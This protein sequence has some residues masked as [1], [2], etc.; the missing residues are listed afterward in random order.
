[1]RKRPIRPVGQPTRGKT[2]LNRL[3][4]IDIY[5]ALAMPGVLTYGSPLVVDVGFGA[6][7]WTT[8]EMRQRWLHLNASLRVLGIEIAPERVEAALPYAA[9]PAI[10]FKL[11]G[12]NVLDATGG[13]RV[14][15]IRA[16]NVLRQY[17]ESEVGAALETMAQAL[18]VGGVLI[19]GTS[20][21]S[22]RIVVFDVYQQTTTALEHRALVF[23]TN[24]QDR[25]EPTDF[26][27]ILPKRLIHRMLEPGPDDFFAAWQEAYRLAR[28]RGHNGRQQ[29]NFGGKL[30]KD[31]YGYP[32]D[33]QPRLLRRGF[34][35]LR[36]KLYESVG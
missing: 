35:V 7:A 25:V 13:E 26:Q 8:L 23:G 32:I 4:Q 20:N 15:V 28:G 22:G 3:R 14:R 34:L 27:A 24:F 19:E 18:E 5:V 1:M 33:V 6:E 29:W 10:D 9:P 30:L 11:G 36:D 21:P 2:A 31:R 12:F 17:Q 16:Y